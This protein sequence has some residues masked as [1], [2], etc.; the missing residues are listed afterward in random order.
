MEK[1]KTMLST[2]ISQNISTTTSVPSTT[3]VSSRTT[4]VSS[5]TTPTP[6]T[7]PVTTT[8][9][10]VPTKPA[11]TKAPA[12]KKKITGDTTQTLKDVEKYA[13]TITEQLQALENESQSMIYVRLQKIPEPFPEPTP[14]P[15]PK[16]TPAPIPT[17][18]GALKLKDLEDSNMI[19]ASDSLTTAL[20]E[21]ELK[22]I[23]G[24]VEDLIAEEVKGNVYEDDVANMVKYTTRIKEIINT[25]KPQLLQYYRKNPQEIKSLT[26]VSKYVCMCA[27]LTVFGN[28]LVNDM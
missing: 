12:P 21:V 3:P 4:P 14:A 17:A 25:N 18:T 26:T 8:T 6:P 2:T 10:P 9:T 24:R 7:I 1:S 28:F 19:F 5:T 23:V 13:E 22:E 27:S 11:P 16:P 15:T 20:P